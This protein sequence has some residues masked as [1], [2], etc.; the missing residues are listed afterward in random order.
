MATGN[1]KAKWASENLVSPSKDIPQVDVT[2]SYD[3]KLPIN[4][5]IATKPA[6]VIPVWA[7]STQSTNR[8]YYGDNLPLLA[9]L[10]QD[11]SIRGKVKLVYI[12]PPFATNS[13]FHSRKQ[14]DAYQDL[15][16]GAHF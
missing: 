6:E 13:V 10:L 4:D 9:S 16:V 12:D 2:L 15:L 5:I 8:L 11:T 7:R 1:P 3:G 14:T